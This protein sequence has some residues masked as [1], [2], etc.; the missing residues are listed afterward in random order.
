MQIAS[1]RRQPM[2]LFVC[3]WAAHPHEVGLC[4]VIFCVVPKPQDRENQAPVRTM[5]AAL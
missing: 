4:V 1:D 2:A 5:S 3:F